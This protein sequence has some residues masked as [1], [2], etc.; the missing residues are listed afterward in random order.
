M[1]QFLLAVEEFPRLD[2]KTKTIHLEVQKSI[3]PYQS[4]L[5]F[6]QVPDLFPKK[7][8]GV[9]ATGLTLK[10]TVRRRPDTGEIKAYPQS[11]DLFL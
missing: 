1:A 9:F 8:I 10:K 6:F 5:F 3:V 7:T 4:V 11:A 2:F